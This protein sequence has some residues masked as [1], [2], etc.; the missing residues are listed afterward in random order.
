[1]R[2]GI[3]P[4][5]VIPVRSQANNQS[6]LL[7]QL[8]FGE[9]VE[10]VDKKGKQWLKVRGLADNHFG[11]IQSNQLEEIDE[12]SSKKLITDFAFALD[13]SQS[14]RGN[15]HHFQIPIGARLP[16]FD[17]LRFSLFGQNYE[18]SGQ[19]VSP[20]E[21]KRNVFELL[22]KI[23]RKFLNIPEMKGGRTPF[24]L[25]SSALIQHIFGFIGVNLPRMAE[26]Q[27]EFGE[28]IDFVEQIQEGDLA[29]FQN[30]KGK[31][32]H[33]GMI[34]NGGQIIHSFG[35]VRIDM[36]DHYGIFDEQTKKYSHKLR[37]VKRNLP[38]KPEEE[39]LK[40]QSEEA[41]VLDQKILFES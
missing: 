15:N 13:L 26:L 28:N 10:V 27:I 5:S 37:L 1:M 3:C 8:L 25:D 4:L 31:V 22:P 21:L 11:W 7:S 14:I 18:Y 38:L 20:Q 23:A 16:Q 32:S 30:R 39:I 17:G 40:T 36:L 24:G 6:E 12:K 2:F 35:R 33:V 29:F 19:A 41:T 34:L 9:M